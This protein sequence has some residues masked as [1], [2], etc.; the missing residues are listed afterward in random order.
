MS[1]SI[2]NIRIPIIVN[3]HWQIESGQNI[4]INQDKITSITH[5]DIQ[6]KTTI[7]GGGRL[8]TPALIDCHTHLVYAG[9][10]AHEFEMR[11]NGKTY[12][13]IALAGGGIQSTVSATQN[14]SFDEL[15]AKTEQRLLQYLQQGVGTIEIK[16]GYGQNT[17]TEIRQL[18]VA[19][20]LAQKYPIR[21]IT[22]FLGAHACPKNMTKD[23]FIDYLI[24][25]SLP[26]V[27]ALGLADAVDGFCENIG[28]FAGAN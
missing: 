20:A 16:S 26:K 9:N 12:Q 1:T 15:F 7:D 22:S 5:L 18:Q 23:E 27:K 11:L 10:R 4:Y 8:A 13:E 6:T 28:F 2:K 17:E 3:G 14:A 19:R 24:E 25:D 21:I